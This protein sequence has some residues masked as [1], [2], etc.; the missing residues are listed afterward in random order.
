MKLS[1]LQKYILLAGYG[2]K[3]K[4]SRG[5]L[6]KFYDRQ[7]R[8]PKK[9]DRVNIITK[10]LERLIDN[11]FL[12]GYGMRTPKKWFIK[13]IKLTAVGR[14]AGRKLQGEQASLPFK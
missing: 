14:R 13:E 8:K 1:H 11:G 10:S 6:L 12:T 7:K 9:E 3:E 4:F 5:R 2:E